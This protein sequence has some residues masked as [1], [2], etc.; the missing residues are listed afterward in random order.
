MSFSSRDGREARSAVEEE[1][2]FVKKRP[3]I[4]SPD[5]EELEIE[6]KPS[7]DNEGNSYDSK[8]VPYLSNR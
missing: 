3:R 1:E 4:K 5:F 6:N 7:E 8:G 2:I